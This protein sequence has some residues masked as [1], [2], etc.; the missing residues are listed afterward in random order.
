VGATGADLS[1]REERVRKG[2]LARALTAGVQM[3]E[4]VRD[5][6]A[7][8]FFSLFVGKHNLARTFARLIRKLRARRLNPLSWLDVDPA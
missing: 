1:G 7:Y 8:S 4:R 6:V 3:R 5:R 2:G